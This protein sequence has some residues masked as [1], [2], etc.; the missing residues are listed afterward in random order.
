MA[1]R[2]ASSP[3]TGHASWPTTS[4]PPRRN[5]AAELHTLPQRAAPD[6]STSRSGSTLSARPTIAPADQRPDPEGA[7][8]PRR[9]PADRVGAD[10][11]PGARLAPTRARR[12]ASRARPAA[13]SAAR[14]ARP[15]SSASGATWR[16]PR[17]STRS[18]FWR[19]LAR[20]RR[21]AADERRVHGHGRAAAQH[22][23]R[24]RGGR[25]DHRPATASGSARATS[26]SAPAASCPAS[27]G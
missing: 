25:R 14:S 21:P 8:P 2:I 16:W 24:A 12:C 1:R 23:A 6:D 17:S 15:V 27:S 9:R 22:G 20:R 3:P 18:R 4:G 13:P 19:Q 7:P 5:R 26:R 10:A 11:L